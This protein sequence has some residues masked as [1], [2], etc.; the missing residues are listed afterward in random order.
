MRFGLAPAT[1]APRMRFE[2]SAAVAAALA[3]SVAVFLVPYS[4]DQGIFD[5]NMLESLET[6]SFAASDLDLAPFGVQGPQPRMEANLY[7]A[8]FAWIGWAIDVSRRAR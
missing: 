6:R 2:E 3:L 7:H 1:A 8:F 4:E 5:F